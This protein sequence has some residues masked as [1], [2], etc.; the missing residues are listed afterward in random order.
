LIRCGWGSGGWWR[1]RR[2]REYIERHARDRVISGMSFA[3]SM[4]HAASGSCRSWSIW[5]H[6]Y[7][8]WLRERVVGVDIG[9]WGPV[10][11]KGVRWPWVKSH[12]HR[13]AARET[14]DGDIG[15]SGPDFVIRLHLR[16]YI[17]RWRPWLGRAFEFKAQLSIGRWQV[18]RRDSNRTATLRSLPSAAR[19]VFLD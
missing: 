17:G 15:W 9:R 4:W 6:V 10:S 3:M 19:R 13:S 18:E 7:G 14:I 11:W 16:G 2:W 1:S 5:G 12:I 8:R